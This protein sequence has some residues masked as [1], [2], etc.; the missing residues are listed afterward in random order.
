M[1]S[2]SSMILWWPRTSDLGIPVPRTV[3]IAIDPPTDAE[4][5][6]YTCTVHH[7]ADVDV[8]DPECRSMISGYDERIAAAGEEIGF[9]LFVRTDQVSGK[10]GWNDTCYVPDAAVLRRRL[11]SVIEEHG[12]ALWMEG[13]EGAV[14][15]LA[16][17]EFLDLDAPFRAFNGMPVARERR[18]FVSDGEVVCHH[19]YWEDADNIEKGLAYRAADAPA[20]W[21][22]LHAELNREPDDEVVLLSDYARRVSAAIEGAWSVDFAYA[23]DGTW[24]LIDMAQADRSWHPEHGAA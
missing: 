24:Y 21:R 16:L 14:S 13:P 2:P 1:T 19:P 23:R 20:N 5:L 17:R 12:T 7:P 18:Y 6:I 4:V 15:A 11:G 8:D 22:E 3:M 9:P 10:H